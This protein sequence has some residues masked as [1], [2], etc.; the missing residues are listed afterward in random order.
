MK[1]K[2]TLLIVAIVYIAIIYRLVRPGS[3]GPAIVTNI[4]SVLADLVRGA[5]GETY[6]STTGQWGAGSS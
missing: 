2:V 6:N 5:T 4:G 1:D 3:K